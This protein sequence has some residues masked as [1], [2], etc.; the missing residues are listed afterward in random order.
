MHSSPSAYQCISWEHDCPF[1]FVHN[2]L[3]VYCHYPSLKA[4]I[5]FTLGGT[6]QKSLFRDNQAKL[7]APITVCVS[8]NVDLV[9]KWVKIA[10]FT[11]G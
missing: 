3:T 1:A 2:T 11:Q 4:L 7:F 6:F 9:S 5:V 8:Y 10:T